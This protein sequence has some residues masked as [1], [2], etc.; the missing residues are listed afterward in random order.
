MAKISLF[1]RPFPSIPSASITSF[2]T[3]NG[4]RKKNEKLERLPSARLAET[5]FD[6]WSFLAYDTYTHLSVLTEYARLSM[7]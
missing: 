6:T 2:Q 4:G 3:K 1:T 5:G 7:D